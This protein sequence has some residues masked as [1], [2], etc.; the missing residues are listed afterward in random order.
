MKSTSVTIQ[1]PQ[2]LFD[3][4]RE[5]LEKR[6]PELLP[7]LREG[8]VVVIRG[9]QKREIQ[10]VVGDEFSETGLR[11]DYEPNERGLALERLIDV[12]SPYK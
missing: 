12:F 7:V 10:E 3:L 4:L 5:V 8:S 1:V 2:P 11:D 9:D 6:A